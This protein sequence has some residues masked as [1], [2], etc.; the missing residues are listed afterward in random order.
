LINYL[1]HLNEVNYKISFWIIM[2]EIKSI[3]K[4]YMIFISET[5]KT[6]VS[7]S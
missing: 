4:I 3:K 2:N 5:D 1:S 7:K 6:L